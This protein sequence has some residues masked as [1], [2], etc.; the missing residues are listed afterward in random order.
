[1]R[2]PSSGSEVVGSGVK[3]D[4]RL[5][6][7]QGVTE[8]QPRLARISRDHLLQQLIVQFLVKYQAR[9]LAGE[10]GDWRANWVCAIR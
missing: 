7:R 2:I 8:C 9:V 1:M 6:L 4:S 5:L 10:L 3:Q